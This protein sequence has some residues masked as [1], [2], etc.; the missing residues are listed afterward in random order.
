MQATPLLMQH[1]YIEHFQ[2]FYCFCSKMSHEIEYMLSHS[3]LE[4]LFLFFLYTF[5]VA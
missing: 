3:L 1:F 5:F 4:N 2:C